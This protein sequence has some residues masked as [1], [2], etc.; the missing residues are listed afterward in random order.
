VSGEV[1]GHEASG[2]A[3]GLLTG[4]VGEDD[5]LK[6][7]D[8]ASCLSVTSPGLRGYIPH[9]LKPDMT[10]TGVKVCGHAVPTRLAIWSVVITRLGCSAIRFLHALVKRFERFKYSY[11]KW[12]KYVHSVSW[13]TQHVNIV[14]P[15]KLNR[16]N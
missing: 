11:I 10:F 15:S 3:S 9:F 2:E 16:L 5:E 13:E 8:G 14:A 7:V 1:S 6:R 12:L 4:E